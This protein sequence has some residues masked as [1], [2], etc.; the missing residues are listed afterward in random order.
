MYLGKIFWNQ[1]DCM[2]KN[3]WKMVSWIGLLHKE[4]EILTLHSIFFLYSVFCITSKELPTLYLMLHRFEI[5]SAKELSRTALLCCRLKAA[6]W[7][8]FPH[9]KGSSWFVF[10]QTSWPFLETRATHQVTIKEIK[11]A[12]E[13]AMNSLLERNL[14]FNLYTVPRIRFKINI[15]KQN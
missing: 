1:F 7:Q 2:T 3:T 13:L 10:F 11:V 9:C 15:I 8:F 5:H 4:F 12:N 14:I 6:C